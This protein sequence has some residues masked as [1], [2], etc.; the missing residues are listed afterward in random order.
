MGKRRRNNMTLAGVAIWCLSIAVRDGQC[1]HWP[2]KRDSR[3]YGQIKFAGRVR[4]PH[5]LVLEHFAGPAPEG[6]PCALH[7]CHT[8]SCINPAHLRWGTLQDNSD[9]MVRAG[10]WRGCPHG[11]RGE[12]NGNAALTRKDVGAIRRLYAEQREL[13]Q[14]QI[15]ERFGVTHSTVSAIVLNKIW[16]D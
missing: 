9:D 16:Q 12:Y 1:L 10:R 6:K 2:R 7:S 11:Q 14:R 13:T 8:P 15:G 4:R 5:A 3:G